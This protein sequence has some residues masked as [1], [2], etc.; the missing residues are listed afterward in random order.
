MLLGDRVVDA[1]YRVRGV[2]CVRFPEEILFLISRRE[3]QMFSA[4]GQTNLETLA[5]PRVRDW[6]WK[7]GESQWIGPLSENDPDVGLELRCRERAALAS[8]RSFMRKYYDFAVRTGGSSLDAL[9]ARWE[10]E[11]PLR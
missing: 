1:I 9:R 8:P 5:H 11:R 3:P 10:R 4:R 2:D 6:E 7:H